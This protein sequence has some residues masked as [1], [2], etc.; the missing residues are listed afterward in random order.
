MDSTSSG[1]TPLSA[2]K[3]LGLAAPAYYCSVP[4][5]LAYGGEEVP[6]VYYDMP[7]QFTTD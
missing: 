3:H 5:S 7:S 1:S 4:E 2:D 6:I